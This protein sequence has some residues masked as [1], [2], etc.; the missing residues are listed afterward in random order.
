MKPLK[1][2][3]ERR[4]QLSIFELANRKGVRVDG[5]NLDVVYTDPRLG[6]T[7]RRALTMELR[8][9]GEL[10]KVTGGDTSKESI[11]RDAEAN[12]KRWFPQKP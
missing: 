11:S 1:P 10:Q 5:R 6:L 2:R 8:R 3:R 7:R 12:I 4:P 9:I